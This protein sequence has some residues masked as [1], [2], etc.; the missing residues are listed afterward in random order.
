MT[1]YITTKEAADLL[2]VN[3]SRVRQMVLSGELPAQ[4]VG[5]AVLIVSTKDVAKLRAKRQSKK[6][7][8]HK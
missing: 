5:K 4:K 8:G 7:N 6:S 3:A 2:G 1:G